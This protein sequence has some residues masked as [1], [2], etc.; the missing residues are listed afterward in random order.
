VAALTAPGGSG[1]SESASTAREV[2]V[3]VAAAEK[4][5]EMR[6]AEE[7]V[8]VKAAEEDTGGEGCYG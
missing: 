7:G 6:S 3:V 4:A 5:T 2:S 1:G 8:T